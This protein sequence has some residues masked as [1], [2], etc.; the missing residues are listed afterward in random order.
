LTVAESES[1]PET[2]A[3]VDTTGGDGEDGPTP[4]CDVD[5]RAVALLLAYRVIDHQADETR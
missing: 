5:E 1:D 3:A 4:E 2:E